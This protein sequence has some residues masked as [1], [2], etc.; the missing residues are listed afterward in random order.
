V[1]AA[2]AGGALPA[3]SGAVAHGLSC[4]GLL[5]PLDQAPRA[6]RQS[7]YGGRTQL[8]RV[9]PAQG[10]R[11]SRWRPASSTG[12]APVGKTRTGSTNDPRPRRSPGI[13]ANATR[14]VRGASA[15]ESPSTWV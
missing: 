12:Y 4:G 11:T 3:R 2:L 13:L 6:A 14:G 8:H 7:G 5:P 10:Q 15:A 9:L 1:P